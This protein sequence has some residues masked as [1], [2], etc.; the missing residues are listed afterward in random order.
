MSTAK[1]SKLYFYV[2]ELRTGRL[3]VFLGFKLGS[4]N[5]MP[6]NITN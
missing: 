2:E 1:Y 5:I 3:L 4:I 6:R